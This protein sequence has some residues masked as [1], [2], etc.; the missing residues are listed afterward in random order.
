MNDAGRIRV[1]DAVPRFGLK[2]QTGSDWDIG[3]LI[4]KKNL[5][6]F[7]YPKD[8][9]PGCTK[10]ACRFRNEF[11]RMRELDAEIIGIS[12]DE[13][14]SH[15]RFSEKYDLQYTLLSDPENSVRKIFGVPSSLFG[16]IDG[17]VTYVVDKRG[18]VIH[19]F[20][21]QFQA[22][23]HVREAIEVLAATSVRP[24]RSA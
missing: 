18:I 7:F 8:D 24:N 16:L 5:V 4:G 11:G 21:S 23:R 3:P 6:I 15:R 14:A 2:N 1:G 20:E 12:S 13:V 22:E 19:I 9:T 17:R 10:E